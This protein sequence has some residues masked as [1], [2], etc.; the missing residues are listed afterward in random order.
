M[1]L[2]LISGIKT[3]FAG[4]S[5]N[6]LVTMF[7]GSII[8]GHYDKRIRFWDIRGD[9]ASSEIT[10]DGK[11]TSLCLSTGVCYFNFFVLL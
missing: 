2:R 8:S 5:C 9:K 6:D 7:G 1:K 11:L 4:S 3:L 10:L